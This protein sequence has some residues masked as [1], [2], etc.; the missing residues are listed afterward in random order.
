[1]RQSTV[2]LDTEML[3]LAL[4][5]VFMEVR[6]LKGRAEL[7]LQ[8]SDVLNKLMVGLEGVGSPLSIIFS[9]FVRPSEGALR[10]K[11]PSPWWMRN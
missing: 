10:F 6:G 1:M 4:V 8:S 11:S 3:A 5:N 7:R 2:K 9:L